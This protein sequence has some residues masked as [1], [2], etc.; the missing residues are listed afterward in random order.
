MR[1]V[2]QSLNKTINEHKYVLLLINITNEMGFVEDSIIVFV[3]QVCFFV[4]GWVFFVKQLF[5]NYEI[6]HVSV[7]LIFSMTFALSLTMFELIIFEILGFLE[8]TSRYFH[9]R[10]GLTFLLIMVIAVIPLYIAYSFISNISFVPERWV[11]SITIFL[12]FCYLYA[13]WR[14]GDPFPLLSV[15]HGIFTIEQAVS[16]IGVV[17]VTVMAILSGFGAVNYPYTSMAY[18]IKPVSPQDVINLER[19]LMLTMDMIINKKKRIAVEIKKSK[20]NPNMRP[21]LW[22]I[23]SSVAQSYSGTS[24]NIGQLRLEIAGLEELSRQLFLEINSLK[25]MQERQVWATT[26]QGK[27]FN[28]LGY[29]FSLYCLWKIFISTVNIIFDRVGRKDPVTRGLEIA[30]HWCGFNIDLAF[31][32]QHISFFLVGC[33]VVTSIRGL[34]LTLTKFFYKMS[35]SKSS[36]LIVLLLAQIMGMY[37][38]SSVLL[39]RMNMPAEY[40][41]IITEVLGSLHF[42]FYHRWFDVI[43]LVSA[44]AT[45]IFLYLLRFNHS[46]TDD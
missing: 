2:C 20:E 6:R 23:L 16:R 27:Y 44:L 28:I 12:W 9:W 36:N 26:F 25:N 45:I 37:F 32:N 41:V 24:E 5:R 42:N 3:S 40:R 35:S 4:G 39:M 7:Q 14:I 18:F 43:F 8:S 46:S 1:S 15:Q 19:R 33:I 22:N 17:G 38:C 34:L 21:R 29:F 11:K 13:F 10:L 30:V 31:W